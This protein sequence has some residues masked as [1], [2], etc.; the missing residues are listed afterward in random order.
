MPD[1]ISNHPQGT[2]SVR[3]AVAR[4]ARREAA[5]YSLPALGEATV[6]VTVRPCKVCGADE[7]LVRASA[8]AVPFDVVRLVPWNAG[9]GADEAV[10]TMLGCETLVR[11]ALL[12]PLA[13]QG[14]HLGGHSFRTRGVA[15]AHSARET[16]LERLIVEA[17]RHESPLDDLLHGQLTTA[18]TGSRLLTLPCSTRP[19]PATARSGWS[20]ETVPSS[21]FLSPHHHGSRGRVWERLYRSCLLDAVAAAL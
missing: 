21:S 16:H 6:S 20:P 5:A 11:R 19:N 17:D 12:P 18:T 14:S 7:A 9:R 2:A 13:V 15:W 1:D 8:T 10:V 4:M 3:E